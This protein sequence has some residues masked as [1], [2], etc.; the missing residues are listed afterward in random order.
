MP[1]SFLFIVE[2][3]NCRMARLLNCSIVVWL[4]CS[5]VKC[6]QFSNSLLHF[7]FYI[8][9]FTFTAMAIE[10]T[11]IAAF[12]QLAERYL[13]LDVRSPGE[14]EHAHI[15]GAIAFPLFTDEERKT[16]GTL[17]TQQSR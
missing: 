17:Y 16:V 7:L 4:C 14:Y 8:L 1:A 12:L 6:R 10:K 2:L 13:V 3:L 9:H 15:P 5:I 11:D